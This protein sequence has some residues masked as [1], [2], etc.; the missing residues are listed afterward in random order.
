MNKLLTLLIPFWKRVLAGFVILLVVDLGQLV[1]PVFIKNAIDRLY[2]GK[3][4][5]IPLWALYILGVSLIFSVL[6]FF[7]RL[8]FVGTSRLV[9]KNLRSTL[10]G[11]VL[12]LHPHYFITLKTGDVLALFTNDLQAINMALSMGLVTISDFVIYTSFS[13][14]AML[15][16]SPH[17]TAMVII[18][19]PL[20]I[21]IMFFLGRKIHSQ[22]L[23][24]QDYFGY[25]TEW[26]RDILSGIKVIKTYDT[27]EKLTLRYAQISENY[28]RMN[29]TMGF[30]DGLFN[31]SIFLIAYL[32]TAILLLVGGTMTTTGKVSL[33]DYVAFGSYISMMIWPM[34]ALGWFANLMQRGSASYKRI[35]D[36]LNTKPEI[37]EIG[38]IEL[39][40]FGDMEV[41]NLTFRMYEKEI[42][43]NINFKVRKGEFVGITGPTGSGKSIFL[44]IL[45]RFY[46]PAS[47]DIYING[48]SWENISTTSI[49]KLIFLA[50][51]E[52]FVFSLTIKENLLLAD[53]GA[54]DDE[55]WWALRMAN[56]EEDV[57]SMPESIN[58]VVG[59]RGYSL[60]GG[61]RQR[62]MLAMA[63]LSKAPLILLDESLSALD[64]QTEKSVVSNLRK[65]GKT[66]VLVSHRLSSLVGC[67]R[68]YVFHK[69]RVVEE[70]RYDDLVNARGIFYTLL[71][72]QREGIFV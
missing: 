54:G 12:K 31:S 28:L 19:L 48:I 35:T 24:I 57:R 15:L 29:I 44:H 46:L 32:S 40:D 5:E 36:F 66:V 60:S 20:L 53:P 6:R 50:P 4:S 39:E 10:Y 52:P 64:S 13:I 49:R 37:K 26:V 68:I 18:P 34:M 1:I 65:L 23:K 14:V 21:L 9:E 7:W 62:L 51:Q 55:I 41:Y 33:G 27:E 69:G 43:S 38:F 22:F 42:L 59:E 8:F 25:I 71:S 67:D 45:A 30:L 61:Q 47:G 58:T 63:F 70:G 16:I 56:I 72:A 11:H 3:F 2:I 17:L